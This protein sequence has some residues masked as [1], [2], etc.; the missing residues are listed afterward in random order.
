MS[1]LDYHYFVA[2]E[3]ALS[4]PEFTTRYCMA[5]LNVAKNPNIVTKRGVSAGVVGEVDL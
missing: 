5:L 2:S 1:R 4:S 3:S